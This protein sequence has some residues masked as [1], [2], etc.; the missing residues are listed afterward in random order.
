VFFQK[1]PFI[2][3]MSYLFHFLFISHDLKSYGCTKLSFTL[4]LQASKAKDDQKR[5]T[6]RIHALNF[7]VWI[8]PLTKH[9]PTYIQC[10][11]LLH[12]LSILSD[13]SGHGCAKSSF[14]TSLWAW[15][16][17]EKWIAIQNTSI[18]SV[19]GGRLVYPN[20]NLVIM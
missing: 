11:Y 13:R 19:Y 15:R 4:L 10:M 9:F 5:T 7:N 16:A 3:K 20:W 8:S 12:F 6:K 14:K 1:W 18:V 2:F 17:K